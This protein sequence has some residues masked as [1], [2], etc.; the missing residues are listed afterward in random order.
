MLM[1]GDA[2]ISRLTKAEKADQYL[3]T[4]ET[5]TEPAD[6]Y[7]TDAK[8]GAGVRL[9]D[10]RPQVSQ[11]AWTPGVQLVNY[12]SDKG[13]KLQGALLLPAGYEP[14]KKYPLLVYF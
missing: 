13:D 8:L 3:Y 10:M 12:T 9:T 14:G 6:F 1:W 2:S 7:I 5:A 4:R 11:F